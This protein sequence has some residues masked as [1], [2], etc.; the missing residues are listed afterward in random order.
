M[1]KQY[2]IQFSDQSA[3]LD[4]LIPKDTFKVMNIG[5]QDIDT[6]FLYPIIQSMFNFPLFFVVTSDLFE[7]FTVSALEWD[8]PY[9]R[10][11][12]TGI[13]IRVDDETTLKKLCSHAVI[14]ALSGMEIFILTGRELSETNLL[15]TTTSKGLVEFKNVGIQNV[16]SIIIVNEVGLTLYSRDTNEYSFKKLKRS[17]PEDYLFDLDGSTLN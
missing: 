14:L 12:S 16:H 7:D 1:K 8:I 4:F 2:F 6:D 17:I 13:N 5:I 15:P 11:S 10:H 9:Y 3:Q